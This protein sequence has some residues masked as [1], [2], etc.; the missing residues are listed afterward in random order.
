MDVAGTLVT[1]VCVWWIVWY[2]ALPW[3]L[4]MPETLETGHATS[5]PQKTF[6]GIKFIVT[7]LI[8]AVLTALAAYALD[9]GWLGT[10]ETL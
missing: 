5:A 7:S 4:K 1:Y 9:A 3:R 8:A 2:M 6:L 10:W